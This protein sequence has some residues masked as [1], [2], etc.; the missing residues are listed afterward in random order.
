MSCPTGTVFNPH[1]LRCVRV[2]GRRAQELVRA[3]NIEP[4]EFRW[5]PPPVALPQP[6]VAPV[7]PPIYRR[8]TIRAP[9]LRAPVA[10]ANL[11]AVPRAGG[12]DRRARL[13]GRH[14]FRTPTE[15]RVPTCGPGEELNPQTRR[16]I[17][18]GG[19][20]FKRIYNPPPPILQVARRTLNSAPAPYVSEGPLRLPLG[21]A[22]VAPLGD[23]PAILGW[24]AEN[25]KNA[26]DPLT[27]TVLVNADTTALQELIRLHDR[28]CTLATPLD[29]QVA[30]DHKAGRISTVPDSPTQPLTLDDFR[31]LRDAMR[32]RNPAYKIP[33]RR[34]APPPPEWQLI[35]TQDR[36]S[37]PDFLSVAYV[38]V[39][40]GIRTPT[41][42][43]YPPEA[44]RVDLGFL[45]MR[46]PTGAQCSAQMVQDLLMRLSRSNRLL[47]PVAGGWKPPAG[48]PFAKSHWQHAHRADRFTRLCKDL[49]KLLTIAE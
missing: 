48:F 45:P 21:T 14:L 8:K 41:G 22:A 36:R 19:R 7:F 5:R 40:R 11:F 4:V 23:R 42:I 20:T 17:K 3:G 18:V 37:G 30:T 26:V 9:R 25:C 13:L 35:I 43:E 1:S 24:A 47:V 46:T 15:G 32:R 33:Q 34:H 2:T 49:A 6:P 39:T 12:I 27:N 31:A 28:T 10:A 29:R 38:D 16:C 44:Y